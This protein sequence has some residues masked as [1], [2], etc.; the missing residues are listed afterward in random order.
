MKIGL[1]EL[2]AHS[3]VLDSLLRQVIDVGA[4]PTVYTNPFC[5]EGSQAPEPSAAEWRVCPPGLPYADFLETHQSSIASQDHLFIVTPVDALC[6]PLSDTSAR[7]ATWHC[8]VHNLHTFT[9]PDDN[10]PSAAIAKL[11]LDGAA[12]VLLPD[13][14]LMKSGDP[15]RSRAVNIAYPQ[16]PPVEFVRDEVRCCIPGRV[17]S[18]RDHAEVLSALQLAAPRLTKRLRIEFLGEYVTEETKAAVESARRAVAPS[19]EL[20]DHSGYVAQKEFDGTLAEA[21][22]L[23]LPVSESLTR[24]GIVETRGQ[25]CV[26]GN[27][28]D[29]VRFGLPALLPAFYP[30]SDHVDG[31]TA[32]YSDVESLADLIVTWVNTG[33]FN[34][35]KRAAAPGLAAYRGECLSAMREQ[36]VR[37]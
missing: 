2:S 20:R 30:L 28:N 35:R 37:R 14:R 22:F 21:D 19:V 36:L 9:S 6:G 24:N 18:G 10:R 5:A 15:L 27:T 7:S 1:I 13:L 4:R 29:M 31:M 8:L 11:V 33:E 32:R 25:T 23:I 16:H 26:T 17:Y 34:R 12:E 3:E